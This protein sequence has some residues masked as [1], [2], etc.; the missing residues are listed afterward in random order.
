MNVHDRDSAVRSTV[1]YDRQCR[2]IDSESCGAVVTDCAVQV[3]Y[4]PRYRL[5]AVAN[6]PEQQIIV[7]YFVQVRCRGQIHASSSSIKT[8]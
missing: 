4:Q 6:D 1:P 8:H 5:L 3:C 7:A 2:T